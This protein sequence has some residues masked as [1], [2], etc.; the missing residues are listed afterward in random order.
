[1]VDAPERIWA[2]SVHFDGL[3][4]RVWIDGS[5][6]NRVG[7]EY[8]RVDLYEQ[9]KRERDEARKVHRW[10]I[11]DTGNGILQ[12]C[13]GEH[14]KREPCEWESFV[15]IAR[16]EAAERERDEALAKADVHENANRY[17]HAVITGDAEAAE[18]AGEAEPGEHQEILDAIEACNTGEEQ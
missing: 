18:P 3:E 10:S 4:E 13:Q 1:M 12:V 14:D 7:T 6:P 5:N 15:P 17:L 11:D 8:V 2:T 16:V 9:M